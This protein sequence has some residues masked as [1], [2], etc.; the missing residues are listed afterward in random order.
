M[1]SASVSRNRV[2]D[3]FK[4]VLI[5]IVVLGHAIQAAH[6]G[7]GNPI[8]DYI[9]SFQMELFF[10]ASGIVSMYGNH[11]TAGQH[12]KSYFTRL[13]VPYVC[14]IGLLLSVQVL[15]GA[16]DLTVWT[17]PHL[18]LCSQ[19]WFFRILLAILLGREA[20]KVLKDRIG[21]NVAVSFALFACFT[22][23]LIPGM[24][25]I[26]HY[27]VYFAVGCVFS[28][29]GSALTMGEASMLIR[30]LEWCG[31]NSLGLYAVHW[32]L[33]LVIGC[34]YCFDPHNLALRGANEYGVALVLFVVWATASALIVGAIRSSR[35]LSMLFLGEKG[36]GAV[37]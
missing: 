6:G 10:V 19:F 36:L 14:W 4:G 24:S 3:V 11:K 32:N 7:E 28:S 33:F 12:I 23:R 20:F 17:I 35:L 5:L 22:L 25:G 30:V 1:D 15:I 2:L 26:A 34:K 8:H 13:G 37:V 21:W 16:V 29:R 9:R 27:A 18:L 31:K